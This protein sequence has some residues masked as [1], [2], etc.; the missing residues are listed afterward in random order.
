MR[1]VPDLLWLE[2][3]RRPS[4]AD[5]PFACDL[6]LRALSAAAPDAVVAA[7]RR[8]GDQAEVVALEAAAPSPAPLATRTVRVEAASLDAAS[9]LL[10]QLI[11]AKNALAHETATALGEQAPAP[12]VWLA[13]NSP[14]TGRRRRCMAPSAACGSR[15]CDG[16]L[17]RCRGRCARWPTRSANR[18]S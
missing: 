17:R 1:S 8:V 7:V 5:T 9:D 6:V 15:R 11:I 13:L 14:S 3:D 16:C 4:E 12:G 18:W 10:D 2:L